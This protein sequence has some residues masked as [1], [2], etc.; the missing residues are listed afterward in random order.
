[1]SF[2]NLESE[3]QLPYERL[4]GDAMSGDQSLFAREDAV[5]AA[6]VL[7]DRLLATA[8]DVEPYERGSWGPARALRLAPPG[9]WHDPP[10]AGRSC[11]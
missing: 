10:A 11:A 8:P 3:F 7:V 2:F 9:G 6:W 5:E 4:I 1:L